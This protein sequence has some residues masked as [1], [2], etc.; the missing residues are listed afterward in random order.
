MTIMVITTTPCICKFEARSRIW[1]LLAVYPYLTQACV[2]MH[3]LPFLRNI[4]RGCMAAAHDSIHPVS[5]RQLSGSTVAAAM[6]L[7]K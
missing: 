5:P 1:A 6:G 7:S 2:R 4:Q 3:E